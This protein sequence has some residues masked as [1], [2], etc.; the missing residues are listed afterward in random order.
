MVV[1]TVPG[2][3]GLRRLLPRLV[4]EAGVRLVAQGDGRVIVTPREG[5]GLHGRMT[6]NASGISKRIALE[7]GGVGLFSGREPSANPEPAPYDVFVI[8]SRPGR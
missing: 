7:S 5:D 1:G 6:V 3:D 4:R 8:T 2:H